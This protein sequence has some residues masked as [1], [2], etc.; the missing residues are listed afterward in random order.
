MN[1]GSWQ[2]ACMDCSLCMPWAIA[3]VERRA[4]EH[5]LTA[6][7]VQGLKLALAMDV[8]HSHQQSK[9]PSF[10]GEHMKRRWVHM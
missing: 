6:A 3:T 5:G 8:I 4:H 2:H 9:W 7:C 1:T 10:G